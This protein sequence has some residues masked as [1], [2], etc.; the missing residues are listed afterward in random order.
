MDKIEVNLSQ[1]KLH[2]TNDTYLEELQY[3]RKVALDNFPTRMN[4]NN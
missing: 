3:W 4:E 2:L 1:E